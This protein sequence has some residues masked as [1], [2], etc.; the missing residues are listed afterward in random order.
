MT[1]EIIGTR[2]LQ[3]HFKFTCTSDCTSVTE[4]SRKIPNK[5]RVGDHS[6]S[7][8]KYLVRG[9]RGRKVEFY[10]LD[11][12]YMP[13]LS[14]FIS[15]FTVLEFKYVQVFVFKRSCSCISFSFVDSSIFISFSLVDF[16]F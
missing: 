7:A 13:V 14:S 3:T 9:D 16:A 2:V 1:H 4:R 8:T 11:V 10:F 5:T 6:I 12:F 15:Y